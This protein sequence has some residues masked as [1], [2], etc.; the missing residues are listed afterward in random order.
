MSLRYS[1]TSVA[2]LAA[3]AVCA[4][5]ASIAGPAD[6][7]APTQVRWSADQIQTSKGGDVLLIGHVTVELPVATVMQVDAERTTRNKDGSAELRGNVRIRLGAFEWTTDRA[8]VTVGT[9]TP[10]GPT[11]SISMDQALVK[12]LSSADSPLVP[13]DLTHS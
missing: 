13:A 4:P 2:A 11:T 9:Q 6:L 3:L 8:V 10:K 7:L 1:L 12:R 5:S